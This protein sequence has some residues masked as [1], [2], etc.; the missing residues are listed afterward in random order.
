[1][2]P[3]FEHEHQSD[4]IVTSRHLRSITGRK[5]I[6]RCRFTI[7]RL[8]RSSIFSLGCWVAAGSRPSCME[9]RSL[10]DS[11]SKLATSDAGKSLRVVLVVLVR[12]IDCCKLT[13]SA[14][15]RA[16]TLS[17]QHSKKATPKRR[18]F[19]PSDSSACTMTGS[20]STGLSACNTY[21]HARAVV[22]SYMMYMAAS[23]DRG[24]PYRTEPSIK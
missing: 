8:K 15:Q 18:G 20:V 23:Q 10:N 7:L 1:M 21:Y 17:P 12:T 9:N 24:T 22:V 16:S 11:K 6:Y 5:C 19:L 2:R 13:P 14:G 3:A 4:P